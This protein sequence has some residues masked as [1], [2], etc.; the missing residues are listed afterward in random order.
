MLEQKDLEDIEKI[1]TKTVTE[2]ATE[3]VTKIVTEIVD[4]RVT[5]S[6]SFLLDEIERSQKYTNAKIDELKK[7]VEELKQQYRLIS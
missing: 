4:D 1:V 6:E 5:R 2:V 3:I 7:D